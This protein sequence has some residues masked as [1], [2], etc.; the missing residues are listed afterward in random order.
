M[1]DCPIKFE[2]FLPFLDTL[3]ARNDEVP[4]S[5]ET[6]CTYLVTRHTTF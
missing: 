6:S 1:L 3:S 2:S 5:H 4:T